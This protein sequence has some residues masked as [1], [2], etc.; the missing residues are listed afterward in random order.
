MQQNLSLILDFLLLRVED[1]HSYKYNVENCIKIDKTFLAS[2]EC[3]SLIAV[4][5]SSIGNSTLFLLWQQVLDTD[6]NSSP[7]NFRQILDRREFY[8]Y[9]ITQHGFKAGK[10]I[11]SAILFVMQSFQLSP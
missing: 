2:E 5:I 9:R 11:N 6:A 8:F 1:H 4:Q 3:F 10:I 7:Y